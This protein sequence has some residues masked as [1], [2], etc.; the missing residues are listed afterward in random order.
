M[1]KRDMMVK[2]KCAGCGVWFERKYRSDTK[3]KSQY[4]AKTCTAT[5]SK[6]VRICE[7][8]GGPFQSRNTPQRFCCRKCAEENRKAETAQRNVPRP[9]KRLLE[10]K[11]LGD[12]RTRRGRVGFHNRLRRHARLV[13][14]RS[15]LPMECCVCGYERG[16]DVCHIRPV[17]DF[18]DT[19]LVGEVNS[20]DNLMVLDKLCHWEYDNGLLLIDW[21]E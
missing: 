9:S 13:Y 12:L 15:G 3:S 19:A 6:V 17:G 1:L 5:I 2:L 21:D 16:L 10:S 18:P 7:Y 20:L 8:C 4:C 14:E 11:V